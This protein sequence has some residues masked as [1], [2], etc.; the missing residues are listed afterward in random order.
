MIIN[1]SS[2]VSKR[3][4]TNYVTVMCYLYKA[5]VYSCSVDPESSAH[6]QLHGCKYAKQYAVIVYVL[7]LWQHSYRAHILHL[8]A[9]Q[10]NVTVTRVYKVLEKF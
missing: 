8:Y 4:T 6:T 10:K 5:K 7:H 3:D 1:L 9:Y 2:C